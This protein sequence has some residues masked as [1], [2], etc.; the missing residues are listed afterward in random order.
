MLEGRA[1]Q[2]RFNGKPHQGKLS[3]DFDS[4]EAYLFAKLMFEGKNKPALDLH[5]GE[6]R[7]K[8]LHLNDFVD[9]DETV[10]VQEVLRSKHTPAAP[11]H[12]ECLITDSDPTPAHHPVIFDTLDGSAIRAAA[13]RTSGAAGP[14]G[15]DAYG[16]QRLCTV[17]KSA[18]DELCCSVAVLAQ[19]ICTSF[20]N[21]SIFS[22]LL[23]CR[24]IALD[25][26]PGVR[27]IGVGEVMR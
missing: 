27:P 13:L 19:R 20:I 3:H 12:H 17:F 16:W 18:S 26:N 23:V 7:G 9:A 5:S 1:I 22:P 8:K 14:S 15:V 21:P 4:R 25:K 6:Y 10:T 24:L 11:L 2:Q